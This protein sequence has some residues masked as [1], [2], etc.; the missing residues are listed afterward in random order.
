MAFGLSMTYL[1]DH[2]YSRDVL[3]FGAQQ[4][5]DFQDAERAIALYGICG[6]AP[7][8]ENFSFGIGG[9]YLT[10]TLQRAP[11]PA[12]GFGV[13]VGTWYGVPF[14]TH[15]EKLSFVVALTGRDMGGTLK[16]TSAGDDT[17]W[18]RSSATAE[19]RGKQ[20]DFGDGLHETPEKR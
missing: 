17:T 20:M 3:R 11:L 5:A 7:R 14:V 16:W 4:E 9:K 13:D 18:T 8:Y 1:G 12:K 10:Q 19:P 15:E 2:G 6:A